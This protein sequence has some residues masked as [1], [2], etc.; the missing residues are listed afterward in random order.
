MW[1][2]KRETISA[3]RY[4]GADPVI[5]KRNRATPATRRWIQTGGT[6]YSGV[7]ITRLG[8]VSINLFRLFQ[9][10]SNS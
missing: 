3:G 1:S 4:F 6:A 7:S 9:L 10:F 8:E 2:P 5:L